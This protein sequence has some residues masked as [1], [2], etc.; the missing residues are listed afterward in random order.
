MVVM[1]KKDRLSRI[2]LVASRL[3]P[4]PVSDS[5]E[6]DALFVETYETYEDLRW[7]PSLTLD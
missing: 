7:R 5:F 6:D 3:N 1:D 4:D 2:A